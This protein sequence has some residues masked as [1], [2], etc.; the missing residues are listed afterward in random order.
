MFFSFRIRMF[1]YY[2]N[3]IVFLGNICHFK[4]KQHFVLFSTQR[5]WDRDA[6]ILR[7]TMRETEKERKK[8]KSLLFNFICHAN[9]WL[10]DVV[11]I[12]RAAMF[13]RNLSTSE[14]T[15]STVNV[16]FQRFWLI[17]FESQ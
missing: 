13:T 17:S 7:E 15:E 14:Q 12:T 2:I 6:N 11:Q 9:A 8:L 10:N 4:T 3:V 5:K 1:A 16:S